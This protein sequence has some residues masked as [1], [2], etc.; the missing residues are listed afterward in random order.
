MDYTTL[1]NGLKTP[2]L[3]TLLACTAHIAAAEPLQIQ[4]QGSFSVGG[5][6]VTA[7]GRFDPIAH[8]AYRPG[9][10]E[11]A[12]QTLHGDHA[13]VFYQVPVNARRLP[14]VMW[15]GYG[16]SGQTWE[17]TPDG[18]EGFQ[19]LFLRRRYPVYLIDQPRR[20]RAAKSTASGQLAAAPDEQ[21][22]FGIFRLGI[23]PTLYDGVQFSPEPAAL[24]QFFRQS[25]PDTAAIDLEANIAATT[26]PFARIGPGILVTHSHSG[27]MGWASA[28]RSENIRAIISFEPGSN[29]P[30]PEAELPTPVPHIGGL[31]QGIAV[32][33]ADFAAL[34]RIPI[35]I[36]YGDNIP[37][38][39]T[40]ENPGQ[41][42]WRA[43]LAIA[44]Q[45]AATVNRH[46]G[47][48][49]LVHLPDI[50]LHGN[51]HFPMSDLNNREVADHMARFLKTKGLSD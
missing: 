32:P 29:F 41:D 25:V 9:S 4:D 34:T 44:R 35:L 38:A 15:H 40:P 48:V 16:Q 24:E 11:S 36:Y 23:W 37:A 7:P 18:R 10:Q 39:P 2:L 45:W 31:A 19:T 51:T 12:G 50:G 8:G 17:T 27:G 21:L 1:N 6:I 49:T 42:Q 28:M 33:D 14:L 5:R 46:G 20:G 43:L 47:D 30:F 26:A 22:W 13:Y 3:G